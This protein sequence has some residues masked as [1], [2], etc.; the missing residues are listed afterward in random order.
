[1]KVLEHSHE[2]TIRMPCVTMRRISCRGGAVIKTSAR[3]ARASLRAPAQRFYDS[4]EKP[5]TEREVIGPCAKAKRVATP[6][7][8]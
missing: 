2:P 4:A 6:K 8:G 3:N 1:M 5:T 7:G